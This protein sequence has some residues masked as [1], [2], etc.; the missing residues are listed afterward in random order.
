MWPFIVWAAIGIVSFTA[1][2]LKDSDV[3]VVGDII[4][5][6]IYGAICGP[7][8]PL[9][10]FLHSLRDGGWL[11]RPIYRRKRPEQR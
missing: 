2:H 5:I 10:W 8:V 3:L 4:I 7:L 11:E 9:L 6:A 1:Y